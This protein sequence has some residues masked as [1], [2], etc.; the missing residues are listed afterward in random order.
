[1]RVYELAK[2]LGLNSKDLIDRL[3]RMKV[4]VKSHSSTLDEVTVRRVR[5]QVASGP[6]PMAA[7]SKSPAKGAGKAAGKAPVTPAA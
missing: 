1:M 6:T 5:E 3:A 4:P 2:E 7:G